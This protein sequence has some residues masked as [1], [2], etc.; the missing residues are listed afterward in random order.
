MVEVE[1]SIEKSMSPV[2]STKK[3][4]LQISKDKEY[5]FC[6]F[7]DINHRS[8]VKFFLPILGHMIKIQ[9]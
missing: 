9:I 7:C 3:R 5:V 4:I 6:H 2:L 1:N 8:V